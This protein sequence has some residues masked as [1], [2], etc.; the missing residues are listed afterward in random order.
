MAR[1]QK[2]KETKETKPSK[3][4]GWD[5]EDKDEALEA[6]GLKS[7]D[8]DQGYVESTLPLII[9]HIQFMLSD[10]VTIRQ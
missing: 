3:T 9:P 8:M 6:E 4:M 1:K 5:E 7:I 2:I 10:F